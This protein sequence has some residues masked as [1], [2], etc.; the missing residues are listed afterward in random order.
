MIE[1]VDEVPEQCPSCGRG[2]GQ[3]G[4]PGGHWHPYILIEDGPAFGCGNCGHVVYVTEQFL[5]GARVTYKQ[6]RK[7]GRRKAA[8]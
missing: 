1:R 4:M 7:K 5:E 8:A 3:A 2:N 6:A